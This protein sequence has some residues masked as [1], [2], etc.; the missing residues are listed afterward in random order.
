MSRN[1]SPPPK[2]PSRGSSPA[3]KFVA[4][5]AEGARDLVLSADRVVLAVSG[6]ADSMAMLHGW[7][8]SELPKPVVAHFDHCMRPDSAADAE[9]VTDCA[10]RLGVDCEIG[11][12][13]DQP[14]GAVGEKAARDARYRFLLSAA[15]THGASAI[16][17]AHTAD[18]QAETILFRILRGTGVDGLT[19]IK[20]QRHL[21]AGVS[22]IRPMLAI[23]RAEAREFLSARSFEWR[24]DA[25]NQDC[26]RRRNRIRHE[27]IPKL[28]RDFNP[29]LFDAV[30]GLSDS[31]RDAAVFS[32]D[33]RVQLWRDLSW[34]RCD[35]EASISID[36]IRSLLPQEFRLVLRDLFEMQRWPMGRMSSAH[37]KRLSALQSDDGPSHW[38]GPDGMTAERSATSFIVRRRSP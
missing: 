15:R 36:A 30:M 12:W 2:R 4:R 29:K 23:R 17:T 27:L 8:E 25:S 21:A 24:E 38:Q 20:R 35:T 16:A 37:W 7:L 6:G 34:D 33:R 22:V 9:F 26:N 32:H 1:S 31:A 13:T 10:R 5:L 3:E 11:V 19:G 14:E 28:E 18:D